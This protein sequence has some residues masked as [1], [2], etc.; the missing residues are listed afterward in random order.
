MSR[1]GL[2]L[3]EQYTVGLAPLGKSALMKDCISVGFAKLKV[4]LVFRVTKTLLELI[5]AFPD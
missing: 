4:G 3:C 2:C 5:V 1:L